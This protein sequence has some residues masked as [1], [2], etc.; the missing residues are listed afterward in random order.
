MRLLFRL[1][2][3]LGKYGPA[4][5]LRQGFSR[6][7]AAL[8]AFLAPEALLHPRRLRRQLQ[9]I[10]GGNFD[11][12]VLWR[13]GFGFHA[14]LYQRP[15]Q[16]ARQLARQRCLVLYEAAPGRDRVGA[17]REQEPGL[18]LVNLRSPVLRRML[19][20][21][22]RRCPRPRWLQLYSTN[23]ELPL[24]ALRR[25]IDGGG[26]VLFEYVDH[27][28]PLISGTAQLPKNVA[29]KFAYVMAH[30][31]IPVVATAELLR[32]D[33]IARR[34]AKNLILAS[35]GVDCAF[36]RV[37]QPYAFEPAFREI[38][39][40]GKPILCYYGALAEWLD[41]AL[42]RR[43]ARSGKYSLVLIG[44][45]YDG[46]FD[47]ELRGEKGVDD[48]GARDYRVLKYYAREAD[49]LLLPFAVS[50][51]T[52]AASPVKLFEYMALRRPI[53][54]SDIDEC[55]RYRSVL[56]GKTHTEFLRQLDRALLLKTDERYLALL[57]QE[58]AAN[59]WSEKAS[60]ILE[61]LEKQ[62]NRL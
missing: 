39:A 47:R 61:G 26:R 62:E 52:R 14:A 55:R 50:E 38:L 32:R 12:V 31:E 6:F 30:P 33:V 60:A 1:R 43:I 42:L 45:R 53:V 13:S 56:I 2:T 23:R 8:C 57:E 4:E 9:A 41:Y 46:S 40:R 34:G 10:L 48:L 28:S 22:L 27:L 44:V 51:V 59:D 29:E 16:I 17:L 3:L 15:Q 24:R 25:W 35:N 19:R 20:Q 49:A 18:W 5:L 58:A 7:F 37:W 21:E 11:R 36:F 54:S